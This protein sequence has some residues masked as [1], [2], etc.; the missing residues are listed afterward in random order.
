MVVKLHN[1]QNN[2]FSFKE[3]QYK[4]KKTLWRQITPLLA[5]RRQDSMTMQFFYKPSYLPKFIKRFKLH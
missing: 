1:T 2:N 3:V 4:Q 5:N